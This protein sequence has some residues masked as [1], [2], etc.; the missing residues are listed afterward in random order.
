MVEVDT[1]NRLAQ[2]LLASAQAQDWLALQRLDAEMARVLRLAATAQ[3]V[4]PGWCE[5]VTG[6]REAHAQALEACCHARDQARDQ[7]HSFCA[8]RE[9][10]EAYALTQDSEMP[11]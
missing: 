2:G 8:Q 9:V 6:L 1:L 7:L 10:V 5:A 3:H 11:T 4:Q